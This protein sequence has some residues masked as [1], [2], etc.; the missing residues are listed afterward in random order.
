MNNMLLLPL[1][2]NFCKFLHRYSLLM[3]IHVLFSSLRWKDEVAMHPI[4]MCWTAV[5]RPVTWLDMVMGPA[6]HNLSVLQAL[7]G[8]PMTIQ[9]D[10]G[11]EVQNHLPSTG[12]PHC[13]KLLKYARVESSSS[14]SQVDLN[15]GKAPGSGGG[16]QLAPGQRQALE[17]QLRRNEFFRDCMAPLQLMLKVTT[18]CI[19]GDI[20]K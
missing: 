10:D 9:G 12:I 5:R 19:P 13:C 1:P 11:V 8:P 6:N 4:A 2:V 17:A 14:S 3:P 15:A 18:S 7:P 16:Q 20:H